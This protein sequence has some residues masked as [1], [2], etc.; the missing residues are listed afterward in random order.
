MSPLLRVLVVAGALI[1]ALPG[2]AQ[3]RFAVVMGHNL[4]ALR[5]APLRYAEDDATRVADALAAVGGFPVENTA[6][7]RAPDAGA[8]RQAILGMNERLRAVSSRGDEDSVLF[9]YYSG[10]SDAQGLHLGDSEL[11]LIEL[12]R[13]VRSSPARFRV[14]LVDSCRS[15][16]L[17]RAKGGRAAPPIRVSASGEMTSEGMVILT[18]AAA[19]EDAQESEAIGGSFFT[20]HFVSG[21]LGA[22]DSDR[23]G[24]VTLSEVY[25]HAHEN[26]VRDSS[27]TLLGT[28]HPTY[29]YDIRGSGDVTMAS[30]RD[31]AS[32]ARILLPPSVDVLLF[33]GHAAG[34]MVAEVRDDGQAR[35]LTV[36]GG[37]YFVRARGARVLYE[38][39]VDVARSGSTELHLE[40]LERIEYAR[41]ARKGGDVGTPVLGIMVAGAAR[42]SLS[43]RTP[44]VGGAVGAAWAAGPLVVTPQASACMEQF[45]TDVLTSTTVDLTLG[46]GARYA[47]DLPWAITAHV[48]PELGASFLAQTLESA[49]RLAPDNRLFGPFVGVEAG[50]EWAPG[51][52]LA[53]FV[54][55]LARTFV[56]PVEA[57]DGSARVSALL[58]PAN[59]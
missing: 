28:Q 51:L 14:L 20:H 57:P 4:G 16:V 8:A 53:P 47:V 3:Q 46:V 31:N 23:D 24:L 45:A 6:L 44:C 33:E 49:E 32:L 27:A 2:W 29:R 10:H 37:R 55:G 11:P 26:T 34:R 56:L 1:A 19:G 54:S 13:M 7:M 5:E 12:E 22:A 40:A 41:L 52:G 17:T 48:G 36:R 9:V 50:L 21:L 59:G 58:G 18:A 25:R 30:L 43:G 39:E 38:G 35:A 15:G 42:T